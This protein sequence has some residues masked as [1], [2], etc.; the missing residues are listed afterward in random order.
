MRRLFGNAI[1]QFYGQLTI[2]APTAGGT[3]LTVNNI[4]GSPSALTLNASA[5]ND[6]AQIVNGAALGQAAIQFQTAGAGTA[7]LATA[8]T[9]N[10]LINGALVGDMLFRVTSGGLRFSTNGGTSSALTISSGGIATFSN[11]ITSSLTGG[12]QLQLTTFG[13]GS[14]LQNA[15]QYFSD[16]NLYIDAPQTGTP[17]GG[18]FKF[19]VTGAVAALSISG[20]GNVTIA[21]PSTGTAL[22]VSQGAGVA[23]IAT[24]STASGSTTISQGN[25]LVGGTVINWWTA[26]NALAIGTSDANTLGLYTNAVNRLSIAATGNVTIAAPTSGVALTVIGLGG[27]TP[28]ILAKSVAA[29]NA[30]V[31]IQ[32]TGQTPWLLYSPASSNDIRLF[33]GTADLLTVTTAGNVTI[34]APTTNVALTVNVNGAN[35]AACSFITTVARGSGQNNVLFYDPTG[36]KAQLGYA[37]T[38]DNFYVSN[39]LAGQLILRTSGA[40]RLTIAA[41]GAV[42]VAGNLSCNNVTPPAQIT[43]WGSPTGATLVTNFPGATATLLQCSNVIARLIFDLKAF[44]LY[45]A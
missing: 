1:Q 36:L 6:I 4:A 20:A 28:G 31:G 2:T 26:S 10:Q 39:E 5:V 3:A 21:V 45:G 35:G 37:A 30:S 22:T 42:T 11:A 7:I 38:N 25:G 44:G 29:T 23:N 18:G 40:S 12:G 43:G 9:T 27:T 24:F 17:A 34:A 14:T 8:G 33:N 13:A 32:Q 15:F 19:R 16:N 41:T